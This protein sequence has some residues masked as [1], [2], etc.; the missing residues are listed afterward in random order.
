MTAEAP[1]ETVSSALSNKSVPQINATVSFI[2][3]ELAKEMLARNTRNRPVSEVHVKRLMSELQGNRWKF[4]GDAIRFAGGVLIDGQHRLEA[5]IRTGIGFTTLVVNG[6]KKDVFDT[7]DAGRVRTG[8]DVLAINGE[9]NAAKLA[10]ALRFVEMYETHNTGMKAKLTNTQIEEILKKHPGVRESVEFCASDKKLLMP[11]SVLAACHYVFKQKDEKLANQIVQQIA[12]G[13]GLKQSDP[14]YVVRERLL[15]NSLRKRR[16]PAEY[17]A[18][19]L[20]KAWNQ[21]RTG[22]KSKLL[23]WRGAGDKPEAFPEAA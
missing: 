21:T 4:N 16:L 8:G 2:T 15:Q 17:I 9:K 6:L 22:V 18:A 11:I 3:P 5:C 23:T 13:A 1:A 20:V 10:A 12:T 14:V 19:I 7:I